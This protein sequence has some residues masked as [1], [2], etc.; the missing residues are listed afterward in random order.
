[1]VVF[2]PMQELPSIIFGC[3]S[4]NT[5]QELPS[6]VFGCFSS[7]TRITK[8]NLWSLFF[9][10]KNYRITRI[11]GCFSTSARITNRIFGC[12]SVSK[13]IT[14]QNLWLFYCQYKNYQTESL[15]VLLPVQELQNRF[16]FS[17]RRK[18][19]LPLIQN[20]NWSTGHPTEIFIPGR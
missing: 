3:F 6:T 9:Q 13:R 15:V 12:F 8:Y 19:I 11:F 14:K 2:L 17:I 10:Y 16:L 5:V 7:N 18:W 20:K 4:S 1:M